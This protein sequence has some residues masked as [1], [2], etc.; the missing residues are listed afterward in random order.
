MLED[1]FDSFVKTFLLVAKT[2]HMD[3]CRA[4]R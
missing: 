1:W 4:G 3:V 2:E